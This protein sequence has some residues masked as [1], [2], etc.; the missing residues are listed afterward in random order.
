[1]LRKKFKSKLIK[2]K[3]QT[4]NRGVLSFNQCKSLKKQ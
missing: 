3:K 1:M 2:T 4:Q